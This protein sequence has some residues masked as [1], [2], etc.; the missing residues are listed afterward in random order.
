M[1]RTVSSEAPEMKSPKRQVEVFAVDGKTFL[2]IGPVGEEDSG[3][4]RATVEIS[5]TVAR[6][7]IMALEPAPE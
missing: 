2:R 6:E 7:L 3:E 1:L 5:A 4:G